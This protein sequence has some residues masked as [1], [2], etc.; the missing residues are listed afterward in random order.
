MKR[1]W[2][3]VY[4]NWSACQCGWNIA[5]KYWRHGRG[6]FDAATGCSSS[7][8]APREA[9]V[10]RHV[11]QLL[12]KTQLPSCKLLEQTHATQSRPMR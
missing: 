6:A 7:L 9:E 11:P 12:L 1:L 5:V 8:V 2:Q 10:E 4:N 3:Y